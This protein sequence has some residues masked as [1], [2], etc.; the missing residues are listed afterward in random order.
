MF[1]DQM[2]VLE[3]QQ[4]QEL[5][6]IPY[7]PN[8]PNGTGIQHLAVSAPTTPPRVNAVLNGEFIPGM[9]N[10]RSHLPVDA[11]SL[12]KAVG[13]ADKRK[14]V[15]YAQNVNLSPDP[16]NGTSTQGGARPAGAKS[17]PASRRTSASS[18]D[19]ELAS[20][21]QSLAVAGDRSNRTSPAPNPISASILNR[22]SRYGEEEVRYGGNFNAGMMLDEQLDQEMHSE[23]LSAHPRPPLSPVSAD[24]MRNLPTSD[25][26]KYNHF[27]KVRRSIAKFPKL[28]LNNTHRF[29]RHRLRLI[30]RIYLRPRHGLRSVAPWNLGKN[31]RNGRSSPALVEMDSHPGM[32][33]GQSPIRLCLCPRPLLTPTGNLQDLS[34]PRAR[35]WSLSTLRDI[36]MFD[37]HHLGAA[38]RQSCWRV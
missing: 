14:S 20:H 17:M 3:Q 31:I 27:S 34:Q 37:L 11:D 13:A 1:E 26:D 29:Q 32:I 24:A 28:P 38:H 35:P 16:S 12:S 8:A 23:L 7:D 4:A 36:L 21:F 2:R 6:S 18:H 5:L 33:G 19:E 10:N 30:L 15:T 9:R 22:G 25:D